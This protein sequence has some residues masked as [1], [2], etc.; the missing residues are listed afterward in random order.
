MQLKFFEE[1]KLRNNK[2]YQQ[3]IRVITLIM[4]VLYVVGGITA[5]ATHSFFHQHET[6]KLNCKCEKNIPAHFHKT[7]YDFNIHAKC[8]ICQQGNTFALIN[9]NLEDYQPVFV[10][11][12]QKQIKFF[13]KYSAEFSTSAPRA[14]PVI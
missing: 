1:L 6:Q 10:E 14:P 13:K 3:K 11:K 4:C 7:S 12:K 8:I 5:T 2:Y 9:C